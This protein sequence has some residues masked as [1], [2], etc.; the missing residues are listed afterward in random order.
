MKVIALAL[1]LA[2]TAIAQTISAEPSSS[3]CAGTKYSQSQIDAAATAALTYY[4]SGSTVGSDKYP[5]KYNDYE[6]FTFT[7]SSPYLE[8]PIKKSGTYSGGSPGADR[9]VIGG[10]SSD[11]STAQ[12]CAVITHTGESNNAFAE[13][14]DS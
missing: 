14:T 8:F 11:Y 6:G 4:S 3:N 2:S 10:V 5:H 13:C 1:F 9:V 12:Y 7:C